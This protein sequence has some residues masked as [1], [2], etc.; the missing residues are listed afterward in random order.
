MV[1]LREYVDLAGLRH[2]KNNTSTFVAR[3]RADYW[4]EQ[5]KMRTQLLSSPSTS[6]A[7]P[8]KSWVTS[9]FEVFSSRPK[10]A[11]SG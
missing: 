10:E 7:Q 11:A 2:G 5:M 8:F 9:D 1:K 4:R 3:L 6:M